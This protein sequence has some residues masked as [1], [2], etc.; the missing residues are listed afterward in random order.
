VNPLVLARHLVLVF[1]LIFAAADGTAAE[2]IPDKV[3]VQCMDRC[4]VQQTRCLRSCSRTKGCKQK[5]TDQ[6]NDCHKSCGSAG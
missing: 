4:D 6:W 3:A 2:T 1:G 5:C